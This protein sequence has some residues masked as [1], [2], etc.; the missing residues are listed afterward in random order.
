MLKDGGYTVPHA[1]VVL[2]SVPYC[3]AQQQ[4]DYRYG[5]FECRRKYD[6]LKSSIINYRI[7]FTSMSTNSY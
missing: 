5:P 7:N 1:T 2:V 3:R 6:V 4:Q